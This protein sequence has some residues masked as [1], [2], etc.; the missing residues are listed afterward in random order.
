[1]LCAA[2]AALAAGPAG[3][4]DSRRIPHVFGETVLRAAP[5]RVV[6]LGYTTADPLLALGVQPVAVRRWFGDQPDAIW[7]WAQLLRKG[8]PPEVLVGDVLVERVAL[9]E[10][11]LI[12]GIG[13]GIS[14]A[15]YDALSGIAPVLMQ[16]GAASFTAWDEIVTRLGL[17]LARE[18]QAA[19]LVA[20][21]RRRFAEVRARHLSWA[22]RTA[23]AA[24]NFSGE[25]GAFTGEDT[26]GRFLAELGFV[27]PAEL[28]RLSGTRGF[29]AKLSP[30]DL[31]PLDADL[32]LWV[33]TTGAVQDI[34]SLPMRPFLRAHREGREVLVSD[35]P[36]AA[37]SFG[38][39]LSL[40]FALAALE[41]EI[42]AAMDGELATPVPSAV[43]AGLAP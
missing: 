16:S 10:P 39:V 15:E 2:A 21:T 4:Q 9:L 13:S 1:V 20:A 19:E 32:L 43:R 5:R 33:S 18:A 42:A 37:L 34:V 23:V 35:V 6:S 22:G 3:A 24:Y 40:P 38:S 14:R 41:A 28:Q 31:S 27:V 36:A 29:Y 7:P 12:V 26:R 11:D 17:A 30:E 25:T 8:P